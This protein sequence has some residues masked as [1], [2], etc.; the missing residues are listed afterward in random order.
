MPFPR[1][2]TQDIAGN[3]QRGET[4]IRTPPGERK[5]LIKL[6]LTCTAAIRGFCVENLNNDGLS[7]NIYL[8]NLH[9]YSQ[10][11]QCAAKVLFEIPAMM[12][13]DPHLALWFR[14]AFELP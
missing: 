4:C 11:L 12:K 6:T 14:T 7:V 8:F 5:S 2:G 3:G 9:V 13:R 10:F 1:T